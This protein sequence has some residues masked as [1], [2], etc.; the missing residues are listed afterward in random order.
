MKKPFEAHEPGMPRRF[1]LIAGL[2]VGAGTGLA[3]IGLGLFP[4]GLVLLLELPV[5]VWLLVWYFQPFAERIESGRMDDVALRLSQAVSV[6]S[7]P[8]CGGRPKSH[9]EVGIFYR[10]W[11]CLCGQ[12]NR[13]WALDMRAK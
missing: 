9:R 11:L 8:A 12:C 6:A 2:V 7:C 10:R 4:D 5:I 3:L 13:E 1:G